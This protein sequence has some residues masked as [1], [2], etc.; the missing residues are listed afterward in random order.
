M[1]IILLATSGGPGPKSAT[2]TTTS[3]TAARNPL[4]P[5][6]RGSGEAVTMAF[7]GDIHFEGVLA[8]RLQSDPATA[9]D[10]S[11]ATL[12]QGS[13][14]A[15][16]NFDSALTNGQC[17]NPQPKQY[18]WYAPQTAITAFQ[19]ANL[20]LVSEANT[21][22]EDCGVPGL[23]QAIA[24]ADAAKFPIIGI[25]ANAAQAFA[26]YRVTLDGQRIA[27]LAATQVFDPTSLQSSW[28][29]TTSQPGVAS[30]ADPN[31]LVAAVQAARRTSDT[32][33][34]YLSW[35]TETQTCPNP[36]Q[37][38]LAA[39]LVAAGA[40]IVI[41]SSAHVQQGTG[42]LGQAL[43]SYNLGNLA[44]YDSAPPETY[45][46]TLV[47]TAT[48]RH[49]DSFSWRPALITGGLPQPLTGTDATTAVG[50]WEGLRACTNLTAAPGPSTATA[51]TQSSV[52]AALA[53]PA[54]PTPTTT[55]QAG[56]TTTTHAGATTSTH[57]GATTSTH[58]ATTTTHPATT[59]THPATTTTA[60]KKS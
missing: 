6:W 29:A 42:Y 33:V 26:P 45:S 38:P 40:D 23:Q 19:S 47:V 8:A 55:T 27:I 60:K 11:V 24:A 1:I 58:R 25:G 57:A 15:M 9:L 22:G 49:I 41:G 7:G 30:A 5:A 48:G 2:S 28:S 16:A 35:G 21:H 12:V 51:K 32:V 53:V 36:Q 46:G 59:T 54:P 39:A 4:S 3:T 18:V 56:A 43:V 50:R 44:F 13:Q 52:P 17:P 14:I 10:G 37:G 34:V 31:A 20:S